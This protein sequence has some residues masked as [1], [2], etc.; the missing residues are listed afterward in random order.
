MAVGGKTAQTKPMNTKLTLAEILGTTKLL[1]FD[2]PKTQ[3]NLKL[4]IATAVLH[5]LPAKLSGHNLCPKATLGCSGPCLHTSGNPAHQKGKDAARL[6]RSLAYIQATSEFFEKL[7]K[8][9]IDFA[10]KA[11][12]AG[13]TPSFRLNGT[14][15][16]PRIPLAIARKFPNW[17]FSDYTKIL[18]TLKLADRPENYH[19]TFSR[20]ESNWDECLEAFA[21]GFNVA[22][23]V[24]SDIT[25]DELRDYLKLDSTIEIIDGDEHD[26]TFTH[27]AGLYL[28]RLKP[29]G[30]MRKDETGMRIRR[31]MLQTS[32]LEKAIA[33]LDSIGLVERDGN[34]LVYRK[35]DI[36]KAMLTLA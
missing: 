16:V 20:S 18:A 36:D 26:A 32:K 8:E 27:A 35:D 24:D 2:N 29:K 30:K 10:S 17:Q 9:M 31:E 14:S 33:Y 22:A 19:L 12:D 1:T 7:E 5:L 25:D 23:V 34:N 3:K 4:G 15:D 11:N 6:K 13:Y 28:L 21:L